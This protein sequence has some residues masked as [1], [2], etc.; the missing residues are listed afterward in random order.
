MQ[1]KHIAAVAAIAAAAPAFAAT[2]SLNTLY[3]VTAAR[4]VYV[5]GASA[6]SGSLAA[7]VGALCQGSSANVRTLN[8]G[9]STSDGRVIVCTTQSAGPAAG[10]FNGPFAI[11]KRDT[12]GSFDGVGPVISGT[13]LT[14]WADVNNCD[15]VALNCARDTTT[16]RVPN[17]G[18]SDVET[19][20]WRGLNNTGTLSQPVPVPT[21]ITLESG[22]AGQGFGVMVSEELYKAMQTVQKAD[23]RLAGTCV[24]GDYTPGACQPSIAKSEYA[25]IVRGDS[26]SYVANASLTGKN[27]STDAPDVINLC[28]R[29]ETSGTQASSNAYFLNNPCGNADPTFG[30]VQPK[31][32]DFATS[33]SAVAFSSGAGDNVT[34]NYDDFGGAFGLFEGSGTGDA[35]NC[36][37]RRNNGNN[38]NN[39]NDSLGKFAIGWISLEN[40]PAAGWKY[41]KL[42]GVS[43]NA[44]QT[45]GGWVVD[46]DQRRNVVLGRYDAAPEFEMIYP[47]ASSFAGFFTALKTAFSTPAVLNTRG[48]YIA[49]AG[50]NTHNLFPTQVA[51]GIR[52]GNFCA[53]QNLTE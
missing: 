53:P 26:F 2:G 4:T 48:I 52:G 46:N 45:A 30:A 1:L 31:F 32:V 8:V 5:S 7:A 39:V 47:T 50:S 13:T 33:G 24:V 41:I 43:P 17:G 10:V 3:G 51:K 40:A 19:A 37:I 15:N 28:R 14:T 29:V 11:V 25:A 49:P 23:G 20:I 35:R 36:V 42:D 21:G 12:N 22:F 44:Y 16:A 9:G 38:P 18:L 34:G 6:L 27:P